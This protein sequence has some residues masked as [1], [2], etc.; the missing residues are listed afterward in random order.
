[1]RSD[2]IAIFRKLLPR[3]ILQTMDEMIGDPAFL[4]TT[5][6]EASSLLSMIVSKEK[7]QLF[8]F[9]PPMFPNPCGLALIRRK[10]LIKEKKLVKFFLKYKLR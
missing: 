7:F 2:E 10:S 5:D 6:A 8:I 3:Q 1:M 4:G 9:E